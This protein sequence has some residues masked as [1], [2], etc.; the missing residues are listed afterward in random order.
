MRTWQF[1]SRVG[2]DEEELFDLLDNYDTDAEDDD[3][4]Y[5]PD[6]MHPDC[7][8]AC[9]ALDLGT[10]CK[11]PASDVI[12]QLLGLADQTEAVTKRLDCEEPESVLALIKLGELISIAVARVTAELP[13]M[14][15]PELCQVVCPLGR[16]SGAIEECFGW[17]YGGQDFSQSDRRRID[18]MRAELRTCQNA[19]WDLI[20]AALGTA[21][22]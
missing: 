10:C 22:G 5:R 1:V 4:R 17:G 11:Y 18:P 9:L 14:Q 16:I 8:S 3:E 7:V 6:W 2:E 19:A 12:G 15:R 13:A 20:R 21:R